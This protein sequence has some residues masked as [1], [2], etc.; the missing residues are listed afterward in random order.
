MIDIEVN[1][2]LLTNRKL[3]KVSRY[4]SAVRYLRDFML[5]KLSR[6]YKLRM[7]PRDEDQTIELG[8]YKAMNV[9]MAIRCLQDG[10]Y[11]PKIISWSDP[12]VLK[13]MRHKL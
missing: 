9:R 7:I 4:P 11:K 3:L 13:T 1:K 10:G 12:A 5:S 8:S 6:D 2:K